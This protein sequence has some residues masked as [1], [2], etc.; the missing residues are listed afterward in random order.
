MTK[1][2]QKPAGRPGRPI[3][4]GPK[5]TDLTI[6]GFRLLVRRIEEE[7][8]SKTRQ[9]KIVSLLKSGLALYLEG[10]KVPVRARA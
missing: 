7:D 10:D 5:G 6:D 9:E 8:M 3:H 1:P 2:V 4:N